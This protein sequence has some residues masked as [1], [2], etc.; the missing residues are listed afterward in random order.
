MF[1]LE[2]ALLVGTAGAAVYM[3]WRFWSRYRVDRGLHDVYYILGFVTL[4]IS[5]VLLLV[6]GNSV[7]ASPYV[8]T[9]SSLIPLGIAKG[10]AE[11]YFQGW[12]RP[13]KWF[14]LA[15]L[16][17]IAVASIGQIAVLRKSRF[18]CSM[19]VRDSSSSW[20]RSLPP[21]LRPA[22]AGSGLAACS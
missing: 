19:A 6:R 18:R 5:G 16:L 12:K 15:G 17:A 22:S 20:D 7:L 14:A 10:V 1:L 21:G 4:L 11:Q 2:R 8:L 3:I 13:F 9:V